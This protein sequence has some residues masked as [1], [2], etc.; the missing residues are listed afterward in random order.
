MLKLKPSRCPFVIN[1]FLRYA[2][3]SPENHHIDLYKILKVKS[4]DSQN[5]IKSAYYELCKKYNPND[6][7]NDH[8]EK[9]T[10][11]A[12]AYEILSDENKRKDYDQGRTV[13][14]TYTPPTST[15][16]YSPFQSAVHRYQDKH[17][18]QRPGIYDEYYDDDYY[19]KQLDDQE[20]Q[21]KRSGR[22]EDQQSKP[23]HNDPDYQEMVRLQMEKQEQKVKL[24]NRRSSIKLA[25]MVSF[26][27]FI[28]YQA[29]N[30]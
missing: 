14:F 26:I 8:Q 2:Y 9:F 23:W 15:A 13:S 3:T 29:K 1:S 24:E 10:E 27:I 7:S 22:D 12:I 4:G 28:S 5:E 30:L 18:A 19:R 11:I 16:S 20:M 25:L 17:A 6:S 21:K